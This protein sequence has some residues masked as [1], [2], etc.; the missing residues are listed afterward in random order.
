[1]KNNKWIINIRDSYKV[2]DQEVIRTHKIAIPPTSGDRTDIIGE[3]GK[4][5]YNMTKSQFMERQTP[6][7]YIKDCLPG[8]DEKEREEII[9]SINWTPRKIKDDIDIIIRI[10]E[11]NITISTK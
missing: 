7:E 6:E 2:G 11:S 5:Y 9:K 4:Y 1:M 10:K 8:L 3:S